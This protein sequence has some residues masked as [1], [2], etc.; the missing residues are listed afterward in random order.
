MTVSNLMV[1]IG[2]DISE[3]QSA[4][5]K[6]QKSVQDTGKR[7]TDLGKTIST[8]VT[9]PLTALGAVA[10]RAFGIQEKAEL[11]L[12]AALQANGREVDKLFDRYNSF[13]K[14]MQEVTVVGDETTLAML[15]QAESMGITGDAAE[16]A[17]RNAIALSATQDVSAKS[18]IRYTAALEQGNATM[19]ARYL[20]TL[21]DVEEGTERTAM[22]QD[23]LG[24]A[25]SVAEAE[26]QTTV[27]AFSQMRNAVGDL[28][29]EIGS[30]I[31]E[32]ILPFVRR[33][34]EMA[35]AAQ[36][37]NPSI[38]RMGV[39]IAGVTAAIGPLLVIGG[40]FLVWTSKA[41]GM[42]GRF[43]RVLGSVL[44]PI[45][46]KIAAIAAL[47]LIVKSIYDT[48]SP[49]Q[50][51]FQGLWQNVLNIFE[52][53]VNN[54]IRAWNS[55]RSFIAKIVPG[56]SEGVVD[57]FTL[58]NE[59]VGG[60]LSEF[61][62]NVKQN[63]TDALG[64]VQD[65]AKGAI[66]G[67]TDFI[68]KQDEVATATEESMGRIATATEDASQRFANAVRF[69][70]IMAMDLGKIPE[71]TKEIKDSII[72]MSDAL[73]TAISSAASSFAESIG[74][75]IAGGDQA[76]SFFDR[77]LSTVADF[78]VQFGRIVV[79]MGV[80]ALEIQTSLL[81]GPAGALR[82]IAAGSALIA[83]GSAA[84]SLISGGIGGSSGGA[85]SQS[86]QPSARSVPAQSGGNVTFEI[87]YDKLVGVLDNGDRRR[88]RVG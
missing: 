87:E 73:Q 58:M 82:A 23:I 20:P 65:F 31:A 72:D 44:S 69:M 63:F 35:E 67:L 80:A 49:I 5:G 47:V 61:G 15:Q 86:F 1:K 25:F 52:W 37:L 50:E 74:R 53:A 66:S 30:V 46:L 76:G 60:K 2:A 28:L 27:G 18:A 43:V 71:K 41:I 83:L 79:A 13:A 55:V 59:A 14:Q 19:L 68:F 22:A 34:K 26:A 85:V 8:R 11:Q 21:R 7:M 54:I 75:M 45:F 10:V 48:F 36:N 3:L 81:Q 51:F 38:I 56:I 70:N 12:R 9:A 40:Q 4:M 32:A 16:R 62:A 78:A 88:G 24:K 42:I 17:V 33:I 29:E 77:L 39:V 84:K 6:V 57:T 64:F